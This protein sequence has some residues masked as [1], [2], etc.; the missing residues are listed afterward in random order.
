MVKSDLNQETFCGGD[1]CVVVSIEMDPSE[2]AVVVVVVVEVV[3]DVVN[4]AVEWKKVGLLDC[5][6]IN[7]GSTKMGSGGSGAGP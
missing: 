2:L 5:A 7:A 4:D 1:S 3:V 6:F